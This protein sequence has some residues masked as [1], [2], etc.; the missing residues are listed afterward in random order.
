MSWY[1]RRFSVYMTSRPDPGDPSYRTVNWSGIQHALEEAESD[2]LLLLDCCA[3]G[4]TTGNTDGGHG[5]TE[6]VAACGFN[7]SAN[8]V[9]PDSFTRALITELGLLSRVGPFTIG[10]LFSRILC[11][12]QN[13]MPMGREVQKAALHIVLTQDKRLPRGIQLCP[14]IQKKTP[15]QSPRKS[16]VAASPSPARRIPPSKVSKRRRPAYSRAPVRQ[17]ECFSTSTS[18]LD[19]TSSDPS[20][21]QS[22]GSSMSSVSSEVDMY[23]RIAITVRLQETLSQSDFSVDLFAEWIRMMP[24]LAENVKIEAGF[25]SFSTLLLVSL[26]VAMWCYLPSNPAISVAGIIRSPNLVPDTKMLTVPALASPVKSN[27][28]KSEANSTPSNLGWGDDTKAFLRLYR[29]NVSEQD[30][31]YFELLPGIGATSRLPRQVYLDTSQYVL[32]SLH[33]TPAPLISSQTLSPWN[34]YLPI[35]RLLLLQSLNGFYLTQRIDAALSPK[36]HYRSRRPSW[37]ANAQDA[38]AAI[39]WNTRFRCGNV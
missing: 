14:R 20:S 3:S 7:S 32:L 39:S 35:S 19:S 23:Q 26:P 21:V 1:L 2:V 15:K 22:G 33:P 9:G 37:L 36:S 17:T 29:F 4:T 31:P 6:L 38:L 11:R 13:W 28:K 8:P 5:V 12:A 24:V 27:S 34:I 16:K 25:A 10:M 30:E 18:S